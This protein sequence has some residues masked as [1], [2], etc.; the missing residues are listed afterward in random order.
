MLYWKPR[1]ESA[2]YSHTLNEISECVKTLNGVKEGTCRTN[3]TYYSPN[4]RDES[5]R[6]EFPRHTFGL[7]PLG[8]PNKYYSVILEHNIV[9]EADP[10]IF[11]IMNKL[12]SY[13][14]T[15]IL[16]FEGVQY[17]AG[18]FQMKLIKVLGRDTNLRGIL[19]EI[20]YMPIS[21]IEIAKQIM[22]EFIGIWRGV[23]S[24]KALPGEFIGKEPNFVEYGLSD[25][26][27]W[28]HTAVQYVDA[29]LE[30]IHSWGL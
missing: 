22:E 10:S 27:T 12:Q 16:H 4:L 9:L 3:L 2:I 5:K 15:V 21:S 25:S 18:D 1:Q 14:S 30:L 13:N 7:Y 28:Q 20:E 6:A 17:K 23:V 26:Y 29:L 8:Q 19:V 11:V 24:T